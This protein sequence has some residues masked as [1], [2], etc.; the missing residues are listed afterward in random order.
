V[1]RTSWVIT[2][3]IILTS[4]VLFTVIARAFSPSTS[5]PERI[6]ISPGEQCRKEPGKLKCRWNGPCVKDG[7]ACLSCMEGTKWHPA[8]GCYSCVSGTTLRRRDEE[9]YVCVSP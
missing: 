9:T 2:F 8:I 5:A 4:A 7:D 1:K 6:T 3:V